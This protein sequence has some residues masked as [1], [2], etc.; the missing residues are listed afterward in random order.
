MCSSKF[1]APKLAYKRPT[2][3]R[4]PPPPIT[5]P[6][7]INLPLQLQTLVCA[8]DLDPIAP[9]LDAQIFPLNQV[10]TAPAYFGRSATSA[11]RYE[12]HIAQVA[13]TDYWNVLLD[14]YDPYR[15]PEPFFYENIYVDPSKPFATGLIFEEHIPGM[16]YRQITIVE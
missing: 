8:M 13:S 12:L 9:H 4:P 7:P 6:P 16:D 1:S 2:V 10:N 5:L 3:C 11:N 14:I 15:N